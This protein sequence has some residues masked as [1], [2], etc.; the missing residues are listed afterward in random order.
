MVQA[1]RVGATGDVE[2]RDNDHAVDGEA[3]NEEVAQ[4]MT[5]RTEQLLRSTVLL[6]YTTLCLIDES[7]TTGIDKGLEGTGGDGDHELLRRSISEVK[8]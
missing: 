7:I 4:L 8:L 5:G 3:D 1:A 2:A 6:I